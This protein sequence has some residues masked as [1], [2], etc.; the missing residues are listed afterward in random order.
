MPAKD[1]FQ[2]LPLPFIAQGKPFIRGMGQPDPRTNENK[3][4]RSS[5]GA[6]IKRKASQ[7]SYFWK[8]R[9]QER[10]E[11][12]LPEIRTGIPILLEI[13][14]SQDIEFL[15]NLG[16]EVISE[17]ENGYVIVSNGDDEFAVLNKK[18]NDFINEVS[19]NCNTPARIYA[20]HED[21]ERFEKICGKRLLDSLDKILEEDIC[22]YDVSISCSGNVFQLERAPQQLEGQTE[23]E[24]QESRIYKN[25]LKKYE[26]AYDEWDE[27]IYTRQEDFMR[28]IDAYGGNLVDSFIEGI[29]GISAF[30]DSFSTRISING[31]CL[32]DLLYNY[33]PIYEIELVG[34]LDIVSN[35]GA[36][37]PVNNDDIQIIPPDE[38][39]PIVTVID[40]GIQESH[41]Y[42]E[43]AI[44][45]EDSLCFV[46]GTD[47]VAD[48]V[49]NGG[50]GTRVA[51]AIL[52]PVEIP[53][54]GEYQLPCF[55]RNMRVLNEDNVHSF[56]T[57]I[58]PPLLIKKAVDKYYLEAKKKS[59]IFNHSIA[60]IGACEIKHMSPWASEIDMQ[61]YENDILFIQAAGNIPHMNIR[62]FLDEGI[63][64]PKYFFDDRSRIANPAQSLQALTVG[65]ISLV[66]YEDEDQQSIANINEPSAFTRI[67]SGIWNSVKPD[68]VEWGGDWI[69]SKEGNRLSLVPEVCPE[70][71][72]TSP[73]GPAY[74][75]DTI[76]T[77]FSTP[78]VSFM[79]AEIQKL[80]PK[81]PA[82][83][84]R[85]LIAQSAE[86]PIS[87]GRKFGDVKDIVRLVG[88]GFPNLVKA[89]RNDEYRVTLITEE[90]FEIYEGQAHIFKVPIPKELAEIGDDYKIKLS[91][92]LSYAA[93]PRNTRRTHSR[94]LSTWLDWRC[95]KKGED[96]QA[97]SKRIFETDA[98]VDDDGNF[99]WFIGE[100]RDWGR[101]KDFTRS[102]NTLQK[103]WAIIRSNELTEAFCVAVRGRKGWDSNIPAKYVLVVTFEA[104]EEDIE[105][106]EPI[107]NLIEIELQQ[108][109]EEIRLN[110]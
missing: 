83:L 52:Y 4:N 63:E 104:I 54:T 45:A 73:E 24:Y 110:N 36:P 107:R 92:T 44:L 56:K 26:A 100:R 42:I 91:V 41:R 10:L 53:K 57:N 9:Q 102:F 105:I 34:E 86:L 16:F 2:H 61:S 15:K 50:H 60:E 95:S 103:D 39:A 14:P 82:L 81:S 8:E 75:R 12:E 65:A 29:A 28:F 30:P 38:D 27:L 85:A 93:K 59:K 7:I 97:F 43:P 40:S 23:K 35:Q 98:T 48:E 3:E 37:L 79:A 96:S 90:L 67:G 33:S 21:K 70:L 77:S 74:D 62:Q 58:F 68:V 18:V 69:K 99:E 49:D 87:N 71:L 109:E 31:K 78:K 108:I 51:G 6:A 32:K 22:L 94:Y 72:R 84:Y 80:F 64:Y 1:K 88:Y 106:Y 20:F 89:T 19:K 46:A 11:E 5:H 101:A 76:G 55:I 25:W 47:S 13:D 17:L 66:S